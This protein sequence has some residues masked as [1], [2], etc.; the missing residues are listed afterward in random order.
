[1]LVVAVSK[2]LDIKFLISL[3]LDHV[4]REFSQL[5]D[6]CPSTKPPGTLKVTKENASNANKLG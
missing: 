3:H 6:E 5:Q 1:M 2:F 4:M